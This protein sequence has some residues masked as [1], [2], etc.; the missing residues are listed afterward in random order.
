MPL[1]PGHTSITGGEQ[2]RAS[3]EGGHVVSGEV[4]GVVKKNAWLVVVGRIEECKFDTRLP[5]GSGNKNVEYAG[6]L[7]IRVW[8][9]LAPNFVLV[10]GRAVL[11]WTLS[12][13]GEDVEHRGGALVARGARDT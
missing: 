4:A 9:R 3:E 6:C 12:T 7:Q 10:D 8:M 2:T 13:R 11:V 1:T 5:I